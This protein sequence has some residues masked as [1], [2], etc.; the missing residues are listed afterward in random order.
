MF[1]KAMRKT[2]KIQLFLYWKLFNRCTPQPTDGILTSACLSCFHVYHVYQFLVIQESDNSIFLV[3]SLFF[4]HFNWL[5]KL[6]TSNNQSRQKTL[7]LQPR[8]AVKT[9]KYENFVHPA[10]S[11]R[12]FDFMKIDLH[13]LQFSTFIFKTSHRW[14]KLV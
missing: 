7:I 2:K 13:R 5:C 10:F 11:R 3:S 12:L 14:T 8:V 1:K 4:T 9:T 6:K